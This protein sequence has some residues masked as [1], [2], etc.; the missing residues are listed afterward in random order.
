MALE[1]Y[2]KAIHPRIAEE[3]RALQIEE[4]ALQQRRAAAEDAA[5]SSAVEA[6]CGR[7]LGLVEVRAEGEARS[8]CTSLS[9]TS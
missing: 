9:H 2:E 8:S 7:I 3:E 5:D 1:R 4:Q 6:Q